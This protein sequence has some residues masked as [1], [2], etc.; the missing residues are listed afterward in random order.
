[1]AYMNIC[2]WKRLHTLFNC[3]RIQ[4]KGWKLVAARCLICLN[5]NRSFS[6]R[7]PCEVRTKNRA[8]CIFQWKWFFKLFKELYRTPRLVLWFTMCFTALDSTHP[9]I[10]VVDNMVTDL[11][12]YRSQSIICMELH[13]RGCNIYVLV[14]T[15]YRSK[16]NVSVENN[17]NKI[18]NSL[19]TF[20][21]MSAQLSIPWKAS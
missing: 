9:Y 21:S 18:F 12:P 8:P 5:S 6:L 15:P 19:E 4:W 17:V 11:W 3:F 16:F 1:M 13:L 7:G 20:C 10:W 2:S 14:V